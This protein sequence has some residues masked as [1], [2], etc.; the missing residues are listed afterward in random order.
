MENSIG[1]AP[2]RNPSADK[3][4]LLAERRRQ[5]VE[6]V[7]AQEQVTVEELSARFGISV[8]TIR[9][10]LKALEDVGALVRTHG[11]ALVQRDG[12]DLPISV[13]EN[14]HHAEKKRIAAAAARLIA[15]GDTIIL[16]SG[17][18]T[19]EIAKLIRGMKLSS[20]NVITNALNIAVLLANVQHVNLIMLGG[21][22]RSR[23]YS[24]SGPQA[25]ASLENLQA[26]RL[27]LGVDCLDPEIGL[28]TPYLLEA[29][30]NAKMMKVS[31]HVVAVADSS[32]LMRR[33]LSVIARVD[34]IHMLITDRGADQHVVD[35]LIE[36]GVEVVLA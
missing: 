33:T 31:R 25:E 22:L 1:A 27:F 35:T 21:Q 15:D 23:S 29:Q 9:S 20:I 7:E 10:D 11:G 6:L 4:R 32:K 3:G 36:K 26:D 28:M 16:D 18:T 24:L 13:K 12:D 2:E 30:L 34:E 19:A 17:T 8:V 5:I 14:Q